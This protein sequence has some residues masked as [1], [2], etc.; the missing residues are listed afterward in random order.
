M[1]LLETAVARP[2]ATSLL[3]AGLTLFGGI[4]FFLLPVS[5]VPQIDYPMITISANMPGANPQTMA[6]AVA[7]PLERRLGLI[8]SVNEMTSTSSL[9][10]TRVLTAVRS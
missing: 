5:L 6:A 7:T 8:S 10:T 1:R 2:V 4:A 9:G 3:T